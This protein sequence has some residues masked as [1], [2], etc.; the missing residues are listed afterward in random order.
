MSPEQKQFL[1]LLRLPLFLTPEETALYTNLSEDHVRRAMN[2]GIIPMGG[3]PAKNSSNKLV[4]RL[5]LE[6]KARNAEFCNNVMNLEKDF[7]YLKNHPE[8]RPSGGK[9]PSSFKKSKKTRRPGS[10]TP[11]DDPCDVHL[12]SAE[13]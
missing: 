11:F 13:E 1:N 3:D 12:P 2:A 9:Q 6:E 10:S 8:E 7:N 5:I 4:P